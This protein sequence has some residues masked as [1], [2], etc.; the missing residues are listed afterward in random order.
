MALFSLLFSAIVICAKDK[1]AEGIVSSPE[2][3]TRSK[4][5]KI[6]MTVY[7]LITARIVADQLMSPFFSST[8][9]RFFELFCLLGILWFTF[10]IIQLG[11]MPSYKGVQL[12]FILLFFVSSFLI[13]ARGNYSGGLKA[14]FL[15]KIAYNGIPAYILPFVILALPNRKYIL[16]ILEVLFW[17]VLLVVPIW[18]INSLDLVQEQYHAEAIGVYLPF[19]CTFLFLFRNKLSFPRR[20]VVLSIF[21][22]YFLIM[23]LNARRNMV[24]S[25]SSF[26][27]IAAIMGNAT[28][29]KK[30]IR[31]R[32]VLYASMSII[33]LI[34]VANW[35]I[36]SNTVFDTLLYRGFEDTRS[37][38]EM[39]FILDMLDS[40]ITDWIIGRGMDGTY[41]Q[42]HQN[43][44]TMEVSLNREVIETG[45]L[46]AIL[47]GGLLYILSILLMLFTA[48]IKSFSTKKSLLRG[49]GLFLVIYLIDMYM[50]GHLFYFAVKAVMFWLIISIIFQYK[51]VSNNEGSSHIRV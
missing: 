47:K 26:F 28:L 22:F 45:Y 2:K 29:F 32:V 21:L 17:S 33:I 6:V 50:T 9:I 43:D 4:E 37:Q 15:S 46:H 35:K 24:V 44:I 40:P 36:L 31:A 34:I 25:L 10:R 27:A 7:A 20:L 41:L 48:L 23:V 14:V 11:A 18:I 49:M 38:V 19:F 5:E 51:S 39:F 16:S 1:M 30:S 13:V 8:I 3:R 12:V 42:M